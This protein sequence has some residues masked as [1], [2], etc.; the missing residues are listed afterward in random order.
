M[1]VRVSGRCLAV[2]GL[3]VMWIFV[4]GIAPV[5]A[6]PEK[7]EA[8]TADKGISVSTKGDGA[9]SADHSED[10][11]DSE[12]EQ[13]PKREFDPLIGYNRLMTRFNDKVY[14]WVLKPVATGYAKVVPEGARVS[15]SRFFN[16]LKYPVRLVN[17]ILQMKPK[18]AGVETTRFIVNTTV[19]V[20]GFFDPAKS[21]LHLE[22]R[23]EDFGLTLGRYGVG[24]GFPLVL[25]LLGPSNLRDALAMI[26]DYFLDPVSYLP[27]DDNVK[28]INLVVVGVRT[29]ERVNYVSL[30]LGDY[31]QMKASALDWYIFLRNAYH[32]H[33]EE[34]IRQIKGNN[35]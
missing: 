6:Q 22:S 7:T 34:Q 15:V 30:H 32:Q 13:V 28:G 14:F 23:P 3:A 19:G 12:V 21:W 8:S 33:R 9:Q 4:C 5:S 35:P 18:Q 20:A 10:Y 2:V 11:D 26:P 16:N 24:G 27:D 29:Y 25:P 17:D 1:R 31:E